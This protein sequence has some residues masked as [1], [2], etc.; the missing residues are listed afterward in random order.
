MKQ[1]LAQDIAKFKMPR[2]AF[3]YEWV[4][5][6]V[7]LRFFSGFYK[8]RTIYRRLLSISENP[9]YP[10]DSRVQILDL[11]CGTFWFGRHRLEDLLAQGSHPLVS[12]VD[13]SDNLI[14]SARQIMEK[15]DHPETSWQLLT[16]NAQATGF[17]ANHFDEIWLCGALHQ[18][19]NQ[20]KTI[21]EVVRMLKPGGVFFCQTFLESQSSLW[22]GIQ[23]RMGESGFQ[24]LNREATK[25]LL[26]Q[27]ELTQIGWTESGLVG[28]FAYV[29]S[30]GGTKH[31]KPQNKVR[32]HE[33]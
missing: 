9:G 14:S 16:G 33:K 22:H 20:Q 29:K 3:V 28:L 6:P 17:P 25:A 8:F 11:A 15:T 18:I 4:I 7:F 26:A 24:F 21:Q 12:G 32:N 30:H 27:N 23:K 31:S 5:H 13:I 1:T 19:P 10:K 2:V